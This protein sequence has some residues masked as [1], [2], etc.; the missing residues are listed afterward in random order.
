MARI[1]TD[2]IEQASLWLM[3]CDAGPTMRAA[4]LRVA[5]YLRSEEERRGKEASIRAV[6]REMGLAPSQVRAR[7]VAAQS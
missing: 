3:E 4:C 5:D 1:S 2:D 7:V 6:A